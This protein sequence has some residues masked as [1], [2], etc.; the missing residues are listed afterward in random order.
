M[1]PKE[2]SKFGRRITSWL[3]FFYKN[4]DEYLKILTPQ[5]ERLKNDLKGIIEIARVNCDIHDEFCR[6][7]LVYGTPKL[8][9][10]P[11][12]SGMEAKEFEYLN[13]IDFLENK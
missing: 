2:M 5:I 11:S 8:Q 13:Y 7:F 12:F 4:D 6:E 3:L 10:F 9:I 1:G